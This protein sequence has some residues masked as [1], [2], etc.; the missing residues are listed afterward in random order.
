MNVVIIG[1]GVAGLATGWRL[2]QAGASVTVLERAQPGQGATGAS[3]GMISPAG[4]QASGAA[5]AF[6]QRSALLWP[7]FAA[8]LEAQSGLPINYV[9]DGALLVA[10]E[11]AQIPAL[12]A[13]A[14]NDPALQA[15]DLPRAL[16]ID[17]LLSLAIAGA[18]WAPEEAR[19]DSR[20]LGPAL[21]RAFVRAGGTLQR[22]E[23]A[24]RFEI[25]ENLVA[26]LHTPFHKYHADAFVIAAG[27]WS[28]QFAGVPAALLPLVKPVKGE[29]I[30]FASPEG[31]AGP[32]HVI[33]GGEIYLVPRGRHV[34]AGATV[35][36]TGFDTSITDASRDWLRDGALALVP[37]LGG[38]EIDDHWAGLR[39]GSPDGLPIFGPTAIGNLF[40]ASGQFRNGILFAP[41]LAE[42][43]HDSV[44]SGTLPAALAAFD[45]LRFT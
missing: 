30:S 25:E 42:A 8:E 20:R 12:A 16:E 24:V 6:G 7:D 17:P 23:A 36:E 29:M 13:R 2:A 34:L 14:A 5:V 33:W 43:M 45:P 15:I 44:L 3:A 31:F 41:A 10:S 27:A 26:A 40:V 18:W 11:E 19:V 22:N 32:R 9:R 37:S 1:A 4:E 39:P 28:G 38:C 21:A 35:A